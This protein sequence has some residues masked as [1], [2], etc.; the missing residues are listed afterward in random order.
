[1]SLLQDPVWPYPD[2]D[3][4]WIRI[5]RRVTLLNQSALLS[6][7]AQQEQTSFSLP[8]LS[9]EQPQWRLNLS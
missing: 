7:A 3:F 4:G 2:E 1:M 5:S 8:H 6:T 9:A